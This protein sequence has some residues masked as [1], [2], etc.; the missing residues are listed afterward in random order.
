MQLAQWIERNAC[1]AP[2]VLALQCG[3]QRYS[4]A[5]LARR[6]DLIAGRFVALGL[7]RGDVVAFLGRQQSRDARDAV[8]LRQTGCAAGP[9]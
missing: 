2:D 8:R 7:G 6:I 5:Q 9:A 3:T 1:F 4:Y